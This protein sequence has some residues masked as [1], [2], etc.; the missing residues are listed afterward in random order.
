MSINQNGA[1]AQAARKMNAF[2]QNSPKNSNLKNF[3]VVDK[4][5]QNL[6]QL[7]IQEIYIFTII[8]YFSSK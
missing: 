1:P 6:D 7:F 3:F 2:Q 4:N 8:S 5:E